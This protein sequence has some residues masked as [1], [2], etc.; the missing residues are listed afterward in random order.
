MTLTFALFGQKM[1][2]KYAKIDRCSVVFMITKKLLRD[3]FLGH[4][5]LS[6][7]ERMCT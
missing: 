7:V 4:Y 1:A 5:S 6:L 3:V 2:Q